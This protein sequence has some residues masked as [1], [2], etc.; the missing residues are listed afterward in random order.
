MNLNKFTE[1]AQEA[2]YNAQELA[3]N[4]NHSQIEPEHL[5]LTLL[6][7]P[8][9]LAPQVLQKLG[10]APEAIALKRH[11]T[12]LPETVG[13]MAL[14]QQTRAELDRL[15]KVTG[16]AQVYVSPRFSRVADA[17][18][19]EATRLR[20]EFVSTE[21]LLLALA[22]DSG[23]AG[24]LLREAG[25][26]KDR[27]L[28]ALVQIRG[29]QR[30]TSQTPESTY[31][32]LEK[33]GRDLTD[34]ARKGKLDPV[35]LVMGSADEYGL[36]AP[37]ELPIR[38]TNPLR[39]NSPYAVS[40]IAQDYLGYQ[41]FLSHRLR[42][43]RLRPFNHIGPRQGEAFVVASFARQIAAAEAAVARTGPPL[44]GQEPVVRVGNLTT[45]RD[46]TDV[47]DMVRAYRLAVEKGEPGEVYNVGAERAY[48]IGEVLERLLALSPLKLRVEPDPERLRAADSPVLLSD[49]SKFRARTGWRPEIPI[50][51]TLADVLNDWRRRVR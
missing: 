15:P 6:E 40:K 4:L 47:R 23:A 46:F 39:P 22:D 45:R 19:K 31:Q 50:E 30:V 7:Q 51:Q 35:I 21:H 3:Q 36:V 29:T 32:A 20:D 16:A 18:Q 37:D 10:V 25:V 43:V 42:V 33:Y 38:E 24:R 34:Q 9:G 14:H 5:L 41:Y 17:A 26:T 49:S 8:E 12:L 28:Q 11:H 44:A 13:V 27:L 48:G 2:V 1:K